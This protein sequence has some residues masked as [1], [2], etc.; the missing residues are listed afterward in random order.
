MNGD[1]RHQPLDR[2]IRPYFR[3]CGPGS[4]FP[5]MPLPL[6]LDKSSDRTRDGSAALP[7]AMT[8]VPGAFQFSIDPTDY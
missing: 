6:R 3:P 2:T 7:G 1:I 5:V 4:A 8:H